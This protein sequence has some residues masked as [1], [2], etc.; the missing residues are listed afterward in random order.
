MALV[1]DID[2]ASLVAGD[3]SLE[4]LTS[5]IP[6]SYRPYAANIDLVLATQ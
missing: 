2:P 4:L 6:N 3:N 1:L 5:G